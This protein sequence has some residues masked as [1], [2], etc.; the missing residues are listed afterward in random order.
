MPISVRLGLITP[1]IKTFENRGEGLTHFWGMVTPKGQGGL[2]AAWGEIEWGWLSARRAGWSFLN[3]QHAISPVRHP[4]DQLTAQN[5]ECR[6]TVPNHAEVA[7]I[8]QHEIACSFRILPWVCPS[9][10]SM[11][12]RKHLRS[13]MRIWMYERMS[14]SVDA[15]RMHYAPNNPPCRSTRNQSRIARG[16]GERGRV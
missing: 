15:W 7:P 10:H 5:A 14:G 16:K 2:R 9:A 4:S 13:R 3:L 11:R 8:P 6:N 12:T 1:G